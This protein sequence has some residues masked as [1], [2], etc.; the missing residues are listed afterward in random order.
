[1]RKAARGPTGERDVHV[2]GLEGAADP[3]KG[4]QGGA[5]RR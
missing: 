5:G 4:G 1:M 3:F 2:E